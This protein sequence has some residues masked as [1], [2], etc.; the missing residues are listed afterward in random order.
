MIRIK[1]LLI[2]FTL[3]A[4]ALNMCYAQDLS[5]RNTQTTLDAVQYSIKNSYVDA[6]NT[7]GSPYINDKFEAVKFKKF[8]NKIYFGRY[9]ANLG[10]MQIKRDSDTIVLNLSDNYELTFSSH[11]KTYKTY[12]YESKDGLSK[13]GFLVVL[14]ESDSLAV[15]K[16]EVIKFYQEKP[17]TNG[18]DKAKPAE[19]KRVKDTYYYRLGENISELPQKRKDF[20]ELFPEHSNKLKDFIKKNKISL[21]DDDDLNTLFN[22]LETLISNK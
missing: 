1:T 18:Y 2:S 17:S 22:Y 20:L 3:C 15:L 12:S 9:D 8:G 10:E 6:A 21:K 11:N 7:K 14:N 16:E 5:Q 13:R 19:Y 4:I